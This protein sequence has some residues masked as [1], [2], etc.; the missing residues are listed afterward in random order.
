MRLHQLAYSRRADPAAGSEGL[1]DLTFDELIALHDRRREEAW[2][3]SAIQAL[4]APARSPVRR[5]AWRN[6]EPESGTLRP[7]PL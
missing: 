6:E 5:P 4:K 7:S 3:L 2:D 1:G